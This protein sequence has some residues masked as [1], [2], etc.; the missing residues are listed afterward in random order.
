[1]Q[2][3]KP[4]QIAYRVLARH[5]RS[6]AFVD[7][8]LDAELENCDLSSVDRHLVQELVYGCV[9]W[10]ATLDWLIEKKAPGKQ[11]S[12]VNI[13]LE[14]GLYQMFW[15]RRIPDHAAVNETVQLARDCGLG[16]H[17]GFINAVLRAYARERESTINLLETLKTH[18]PAL[19]WSHPS[20]LVDRWIQRLGRQNAIALLEWNNK[21][22]RTFARVNTLKTDAAALTELWTKEGV[23]ASP[24][25]FDWVP[26]GTVFELLAHPPLAGLDSFAK[27]FFYIQD[28][29]TLLA[30]HMLAPQ[31]GESIADV[32]AAPG[33]KT[34][35]I[36]QLMNN[37]GLLA[38]F[39]PAHDRA[40]RLRANCERLG[41]KC[42]IAEAPT[43][44]QR[45]DRVLADVPCSNT[46]VLRRR[47]ELRWR[48]Q[49]GDFAKFQDV[50][51]K[52]LLGASELVRPGGVLVY[53]TCS[54]EPEE[55]RGVAE[56]F[57][58][59]AP[60]FTLIEDRQLT[61][62]ADGVDGAYVARFAC[63]SSPE[64][65]PA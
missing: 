30:V 44:G 51:L 39:D 41:V 50:Q 52:L 56:L 43:P 65:S 49:P 55:N 22:A 60:R 17:A 11:R 26:D 53:S 13:V 25:S 47:V 38:A 23:E 57:I 64:I 34:A 15:L 14:L 48:I 5:R 19:G 42:S 46:G 54:L 10:R 8:L 31:P 24:C 35:Y 45:F 4:R 28:P 62:F 7:W 40:A 32:C 33:G 12:G 16:S 20:W 63:H 9:R 1:M 37:A 18:D 59:R 36:G 6:G 3:Q 27:G 58:A 61:P 2:V 21:P 29:S